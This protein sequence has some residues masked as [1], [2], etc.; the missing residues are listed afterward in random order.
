MV[1][2]R[3]HPQNGP[4]LGKAT[5]KPKPP[6]DE[7]LA[8]RQANEKQR[9]AELAVRSR[10]A[11]EFS[12]KVKKSGGGIPLRGPGTRAFWGTAKKD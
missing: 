7:E 8:Q 4:S 9:E 1:M 3:K 10:Q 6:T 2:S 12:A 5:Y 11:R